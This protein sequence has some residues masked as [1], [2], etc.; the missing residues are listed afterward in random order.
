MQHAQKIGKDR[1]CSWRDMLADK[2]IQR[3]TDRQ[4]DTHTHT[5]VLITILHF[6]TTPTGKVTTT[7]SLLLIT[8]K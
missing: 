7:F 5:E 8:S 3:S 1:A 6:T 4:T 2:Q